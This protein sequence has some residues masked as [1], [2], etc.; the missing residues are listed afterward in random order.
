LI[1]SQYGP[2][3][4]D[5]GVGNYFAVA[6][7]SYSTWFDIHNLDIGRMIIGYNNTKNVI[8]AELTLWSEVSNQYTHHQKIW[9]RSSSLA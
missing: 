7:G 4:L 3:Y 5:M 8:G 1:I 9:I 6:Y 2:F